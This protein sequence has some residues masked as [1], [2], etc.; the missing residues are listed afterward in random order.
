MKAAA[1]SSS[2]NPT[3]AVDGKVEIRAKARPQPTKPTNEEVDRHNLTHLVLRNS[4]TRCVAMRDREQPHRVTRF[5]DGSSELMVDWVCFT[6]DAKVEYQMPV[7]II[8]D[9]V[10]RAVAAIQATNHVDPRTVHAVLQTLETKAYTDIVFCADGEPSTRA[11]VKPVVATLKLRTFSRQ[12][13][14]HSHQS[15][16]HIDACIGVYRSKLGANKLQL[17]ANIG[18]TSHCKKHV[19]LG[20]CDTFRG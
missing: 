15:H 10:S 4:C 14:V 9:L 13:P 6:S 11:L 8:Y 18:G 16:G 19:S 20:W 12:G 17:E 3:V 5:E 1:S 7:F 2:A